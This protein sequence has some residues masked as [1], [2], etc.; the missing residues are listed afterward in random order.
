[1]HRS[2]KTIQNLPSYDVVLETYSNGMCTC[3][4]AELMEHL[5][6]AYVFLDAHQRKSLLKHL[7]ETHL[8]MHSDHATVFE[9]FSK[10]LQ[11]DVVKVKKEQSAFLSALEKVRASMDAS[12]AIH[13]YLDK[14]Q[15]SYSVPVN[16]G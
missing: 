9:V 11:G 1:M 7:S 15:I 2:P 16:S 14:Y 5:V 10:L 13:S 12:G 4:E 3:P 6:K 8:P